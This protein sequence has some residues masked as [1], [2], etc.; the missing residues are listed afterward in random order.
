MVNNILLQSHKKSCLR[1]V[2][3]VFLFTQKYYTLKKRV[4]E[5]LQNKFFDGKGFLYSVNTLNNITGSLFWANGKNNKTHIILGDIF[6]GG[7]AANKQ[8]NI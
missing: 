5:G 6:R 2:K 3:G 7:G 8:M 4:W 1:G